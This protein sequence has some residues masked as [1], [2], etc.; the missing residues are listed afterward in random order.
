MAMM[1]KPWGHNDV[2]AMMA[3]AMM[4]ITAKLG[5]T[6]PDTLLILGRVAM[7][8]SNLAPIKSKFPVGVH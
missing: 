8:Y 3:K 5:L 4:A 2:M 6:V 7:A 1:A